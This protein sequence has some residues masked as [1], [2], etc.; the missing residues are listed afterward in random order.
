[1]D[2]VGDEVSQALE[3]LEDALVRPGHPVQEARED[4]VQLGTRV[5]GF[6]SVFRRERGLCGLGRQGLGLQR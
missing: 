1:M 6:W 2:A 5:G 3:V 4:V